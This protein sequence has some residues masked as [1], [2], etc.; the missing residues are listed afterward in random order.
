MAAHPN[1]IFIQ[2]KVLDIVTFIDCVKKKS[3][4]TKPVTSIIISSCLQVGNIYIS[5]R[6]MDDG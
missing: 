6:I 1:K 4:P 3:Y 2:C 5:T